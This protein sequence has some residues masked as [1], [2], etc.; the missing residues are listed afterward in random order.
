MIP[1][2]YAYFAVDT[3]THSDVRAGVHLRA[4]VYVVAREEPL[5]TVLVSGAVFKDFLHFFVT[6]DAL[7]LSGLR[8]MTCR[9]DKAFTPHPALVSL[10]QRLRVLSGLQF[11]HYV[12]T[13][14]T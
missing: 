9:P 6:P 11:T 8:V 2:I 14:S 12:A 10:M 4:L 13:T 5:K 1:Y 3:T 7:R